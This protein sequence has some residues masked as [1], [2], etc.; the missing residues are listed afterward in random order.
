[1]KIS[2]YNSV[3]MVNGIGTRISLFVSGCEHKCRGCYNQKTWNKDFGYEYTKEIEDQIIKD[4]NDSVIKRDG[5]SLS[6]G[7]PLFGD[8]LKD[9]AKLIKR[10]KEETKDKNIWM[11]SGYTLQELEENKTKSDLD[12]LRFEIATSIDVFID[13][14]FEKEKYDP[15]L[16]WRGSSNQI[17]HRF[18]L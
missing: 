5:I 15:S 3:D 6:G 1:M 16:K 17:I 11:W 10:V 18:Q 7:D 2:N 4:L 12:L 8:N 13:G 9:I 14:K